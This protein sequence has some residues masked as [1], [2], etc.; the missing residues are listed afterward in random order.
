MCRERELDAT[1]GNST[2]ELDNAKRWAGFPLG[3]AIIAAL[4]SGGCHS[5]SEPSA[6]ERCEEMRS[7]V[8]PAQA[9]E[10]I[11]VLQENVAEYRA[12]DC[13]PVLDE[14]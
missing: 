2:V 13:E 4:L 7:D 3:V 6:N 12:L 10:D 11:R 1:P 9:W 5:T 8:D 14:D